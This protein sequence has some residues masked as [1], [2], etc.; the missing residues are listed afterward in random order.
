MAEYVAETNPILKN[1]RLQWLEKLTSAHASSYIIEGN[2]HVEV[3][4][5]GDEFNITDSNVQAA[6]IG[7]QN[8]V[9]GNSLIQLNPGVKEEINLPNIVNELSTLLP[10]LYKTIS[11]GEDAMAAGKLAEVEKAAQSG[12]KDGAV[13]ALEAAG[14]KA[15][16]KARDNKATVT[17]DAILMTMPSIVTDYDMARIELWDARLDSDNILIEEPTLGDEFERRMLRQLERKGICQ[18]RLTAQAPSEH[19]IESIANIIGPMTDAQND[20]PGQ[21]KRI[22]PKAGIAANTGDTTQDLGLHVDGTQ[23]EE[24]PEVLIFHYENVAQI[25]ARSIFMDAANAL[26]QISES[27]RYPL[28]ETLARSDAAIFEKKG[29]KYKGPIFKLSPANTLICRVRFD[30]VVTL[31]SECQEAFNFLMKYFSHDDFKLNFKPRSGDVVVFDNWR[32]MHA[33]TEVYGSH[34]RAHWR[35]WIDR[36]KPSLQPNYLL[37][38]RPAGNSLIQK[39]MEANSREK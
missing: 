35:A 14:V 29:M 7:S 18:I 16:E 2:P 4:F 22:Q 38:I 11:S 26:N 10:H 23:H 19:L 17:A 3:K 12:N 39:V 32:V 24:T 34:Q 36:L 28:I 30:D 25:G 15:F 31:H 33:R 5:M 27:D 37:G 8:R 9:E 6:S 21:I 1:F 13:T 20:F